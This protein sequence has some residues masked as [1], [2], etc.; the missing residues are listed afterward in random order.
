MNIVRWETCPKC[1]HESWAVF[2][3]GAAD[4]MICG[5]SERHMHLR[6]NTEQVAAILQTVYEWAQD[7][8]GAKIEIKVGAI[9]PS[10]RAELSS[11]VVSIESETT[12]EPGQTGWL[13]CSVCGNHYPFYDLSHGEGEDP[14]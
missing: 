9:C 7:T 1:G 11:E 3:D 6:A 5:W 14:E 4:C 13:K 8:P 10:C 12:G 2:D